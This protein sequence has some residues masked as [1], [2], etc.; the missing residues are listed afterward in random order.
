MHSAT[1]CRRRTT[2]GPIPATRCRCPAFAYAIRCRLTLDRR[3]PGPRP[4]HSNGRRRRLRLCLPGGNSLQIPQDSA[5]VTVRKSCCGTGRIMAT[6]PCAA[7]VLTVLTTSSN[8]SPTPCRLSSVDVEDPA[9]A[10]ADTPVFSLPACLVLSKDTFGH[11]Q[12]LSGLG[13]LE[14]R[15]FRT[16]VDLH[17]L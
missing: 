17:S 9:V 5:S 11:T 15:A 12:D 8:V 3:I 16:V 7:T 10:G 14:P 2:T 4:M 6:F 13:F 1:R